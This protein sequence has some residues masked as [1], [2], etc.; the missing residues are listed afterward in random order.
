MTGAQSLEMAIRWAAITNVPRLDPFIVTL[1]AAASIPESVVDQ[2]FGW[3][4]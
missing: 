4:G 3:V 1:A 2:I